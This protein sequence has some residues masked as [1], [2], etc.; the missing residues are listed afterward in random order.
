MNSIFNKNFLREKKSNLMADGPYDINFQVLKS[1]WLPQNDF[2][3]LSQGKT[4]I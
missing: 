2:C 4:N 3:F 1:V